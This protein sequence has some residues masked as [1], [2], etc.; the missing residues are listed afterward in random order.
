MKEIPD[1]LDSRDAGDPEP[2]QVQT[3]VELN[4]MFG[5]ESGE[6]LRSIVTMAGTPWFAAREEAAKGARP[7]IGIE[8]VRDHY[9]AFMNRPD[10]PEAA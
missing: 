7:V 4:R 1:G 2:A 5:G 6:D 10:L 8:P 9:R 3:V